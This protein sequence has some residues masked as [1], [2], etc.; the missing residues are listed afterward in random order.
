MQ[1]SETF[2]PGWPGIPARWT[3]SAKTGLGT[4]IGRESR[5]WFTLGNGILNE[6]Y[7]PRVDC[8]CTRDL[9]LIVTDGQSLFSEE[10]RDTRSETTMVEPGV[11][12]YRIRNTARDGRYEIEKEV[13]TDPWRDVVLQRVRFVP[14]S[15]TLADYRLYV[16]L[17]PHLANWG[18]A[19]TA[20]VGDYKGTPMLFAERDR[21]ALALACSAPWRA[22]SAG[23][24]GVSDGWQQ[25][26]G[27]KR[28]THTYHPGTPRAHIALRDVSLTIE[29]GACAAIIGVTGSG[30]STLV[31]HFNGLLRPTSGRVIVDGLD[32]GAR[33]TRGTDLQALR[34][35]VGLLFQ[36]PE[37]QLFA[38]TVYDDVAFG[39]RQLGLSPSAVRARVAWALDAVAL[40]HDDALLARSPFAL[41]GGQR[42]RVALAGV[43]AM[44]P[45]TLVLD[46]P[47]AGLDAEA[48]AELYA[49]LRTL[50]RENGLTLVLVSHDMS[51]V[52]EL[53]DQLV[54]LTEGELRLAGAPD[55]VFGD[56]EAIIAAG[57]LPPPLAL[58]G[59]L[60]RARGLD[61]PPDATTP[62]A[63]ATALLR[64]LERRG[65]DAR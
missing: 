24:V 62:D 26:R 37:A 64:A 15:G 38:A 40:G 9:G 28:L 11:P 22:R 7:Y 16:L 6:I 53:A 49:Q 56:T 42:R 19:N 61:V 4:A 10:K 54:V 34:Q 32:V 63:T 57:L 27:D 44:R 25:L 47:S 23:F 17:A 59:A 5:V 45:R 55:Q 1:D 65:D 41:S 33:A 12:A 35:H 46:E 36:F 50:R 48:R 30:K 21:Y 39:P 43:L 13:L 51:E 58:V 3:S 60:A 8:A 29:D 20:W 2:A 31:Q 18:S 14:L 52:A